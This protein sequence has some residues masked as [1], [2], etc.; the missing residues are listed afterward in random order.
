MTVTELLQAYVQHQADLGRAPATLTNYRRDLGK[1]I[2]LWDA[3][4][5]CQLLTY[6]HCQVYRESNADR[7]PGTRAERTTLLRQWLA[8]AV[9]EGHLWKNPMEGV[10]EPTVRPATAWVPNQGQVFQLLAAP[11]R[12]TIGGQRDLTLLELMYGT[13]LRR[14]EL[15]ALNLQDW[16]FEQRGLY[17]A[18]GK[19][20]KP[21]LQP[22]GENLARQM[23][24]YLTET[25]PWL[26]RDDSETALL[27]DNL[28][29]RF[30]YYRFT[31]C[32]KDYCKAQ[33]LP[34][35]LPHA[36]RRAFATHLLLQGAAL[37][38]VQLLLG[39]ADPQVTQRYTKIEVVE[40]QREYQRTHPRA[41][42]RVR[43]LP[44]GPKALVPVHP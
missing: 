20:D 32:L 12:D 24:L 17:V 34:E 43:R 29:R 44:G 2:A 31:Q 39:H 8:W 28:G 1:A 25:R 21:R 42:V 38:E 5:D 41:R 6:Q 36:L 13:G 4:L 18:Q 30:P 37:H 10:R 27:L 33:K 7:A 40:L 3:E 35:I 19:G 14:R 15:W 26:A 9:K 11:R 22:V 23:E 16:S